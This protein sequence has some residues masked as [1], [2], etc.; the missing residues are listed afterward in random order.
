MV[1]LGVPFERDP[2]L[3]LLKVEK[4]PKQ[5]QSY[6]RISTIEE[7]LLQ[8]PGIKTLVIS[9]GYDPDTTSYFYAI[10]CPGNRHQVEK[11]LQQESGGTLSGYYIDKTDSNSMT[12]RY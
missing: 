7:R 12:F 11:L 2:E 3:D 4:L 9:R 10:Y 6:D 8:F 1:Q 5:L